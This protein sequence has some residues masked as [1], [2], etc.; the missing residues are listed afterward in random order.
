MDKYPLVIE[1]L[2]I[3]NSKSG[4]VEIIKDLLEYFHTKL[5][6]EAVAIR[7]VEGE[8]YPY[9][10]SKGFPN[11]FIHE[12]NSLCSRDASKKIRRDNNGIPM[13]ECMCGNILRERFDPSFPFFTD[14]GSFWTN[15]SSKLLSSTSKEERQAETRNTCNSIGYESVALIPI[16]IDTEVIG[17][18]QL[19]DKKENKFTLD[20]IES[21]EFVCEHIGIAL[22]RCK[23]EEQIREK[24][25]LESIVEMAGATCHEI[26]QPLQVILGNSEIILNKIVTKTDDNYISLIEDI[27]KSAYRMSIITSKMQKIT[28]YQT[29]HYAGDTDIIDLENVHD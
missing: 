4:N 13:L 22:L 5:D 28:K 24:I 20:L 21:L 27:N 26:N 23:T 11:S 18:L 2:K 16:R 19:N 17:L 15:G 14:K 25:K 12:E 6:I 7:L 8:D 3:V 10:S 29:K 1:T 9:F